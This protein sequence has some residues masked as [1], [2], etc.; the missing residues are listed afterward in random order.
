MTNKNIG[1]SILCVV[2]AGILGY[3]IG[4][5]HKEKPVPLADF[6][7]K[8]APDN[9]APDTAPKAHPTAAPQAIDSGAWANKSVDELAASLSKVMMPDEE[10]NKLQDAIYQTS[11]N[12]L[13][14]QAQSAN[15]QVS[16]STQQEL[17]DTISKKYS[18]QYFADMNANSIKEVPKERLVAILSFYDTPA[19][20]DFLRLSP[21]IIENT[22]ATV[23]ADISQWLPTTIE[24]IINKLK[25]GAPRG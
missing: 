3:F 5:R 15:L 21:K 1:I 23:Q 4:S 2:L 8:T 17:K 10:Y 24:S 20:Q 12:L 16:E 6:E 7:E 25:A 19:G 18:R 11:L 14:A 22:M 9:A 13:M